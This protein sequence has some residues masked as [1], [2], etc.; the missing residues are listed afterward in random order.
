M[1]CAR[2]WC[3]DLYT[4]CACNTYSRILTLFSQE[5]LKMARKGRNMQLLNIVIKYTYVTQLCST[6]HQ[7]KFIHT[8][9]G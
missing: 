1:Y 3:R 8:Q 5:N 9:W 6:A 7:S 2:T 4:T